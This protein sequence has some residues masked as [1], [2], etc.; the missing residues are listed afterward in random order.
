MSYYHVLEMQR[1]F[2]RAR[3]VFHIPVPVIQTFAK[4]ILQAAVAI[5]SKDK[6]SAVTNTPDEAAKL[7]SGELVEKVESFKFSSTNLTDE[8]RL[9]EI[10]NRYTT[11][12]KEY[13]DELKITLN[14]MGCEG[15]V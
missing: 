2:K 14:F 4:I 12:E 1:D 6:E 13:I 7:T 3:V 10:K 9:Q 8:E 5:E 15:D 11:L